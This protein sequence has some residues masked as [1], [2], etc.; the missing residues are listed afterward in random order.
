M[1]YMSA[2][3]S[4]GQEVHRSTLARDLELQVPSLL[5]DILTF[6]IYAP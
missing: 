2:N 3:A 4:F 1:D 6:V 5:T